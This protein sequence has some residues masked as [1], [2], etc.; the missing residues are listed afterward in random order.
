MPKTYPKNHPKKTDSKIKNKVQPKTTS[1]TSS[2]TYW[3]MLTVTMVV[4]G[5]VY[6]YTMKVAAA[7]IGLL[8]GSVLFIIGFAYY[9]KFTSSSLKISSRATFL[10]V[11]AS[12]I[13]FCIWAAIV[14]FSNATGLRVQIASSIGNNFFATTTLII[15]LISG[16][17]IG[18]VIGK[19][20]E[21]ISLFF[22]S[23]F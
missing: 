21:K 11:G 6:G 4:F 13:G 19:N 12:V 9:L 23:K 15:C 22:E 14:L 2:K 10:F 17:F 1:I 5:S 18:D 7:G 20:K 16:A 8:L 3:L